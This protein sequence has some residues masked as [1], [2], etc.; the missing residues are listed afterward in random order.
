MNSTV[1]GIDHDRVAQLMAVFGVS[2]TF[3]LPANIYVLWL[4]QREGRLASDIFYFNLSLEEIL[5]SMSIIW[6]NLGYQNTC[7]PCFEVF[8]FSRGL[9]YT[10]RPLFQCLICVE[11]YVG[12]NHPVLFLRFK[13]LRH[14][15]SCCAVGWLL[16]TLS[17]IYSKYTRKNMRHLFIVFTQNLVIFFVVLFC[18]VSVVRTLKRPGPGGNTAQ[19][20]KRNRTKT[21]AIKIL[22]V[23]MA[24]ITVNFVL[25]TA[26]IPLQLYLP[27]AEFIYVY[28][29]FTCLSFISG[30]MQLLIYMQRAEK[31]LCFKMH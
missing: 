31:I 13:P 28:L 8:A 29:T 17:C 6:I 14:R 21:R 16:I 26:P 25:C 18:L 10:G 22:L 7:E 1:E 9:F 15:L 19:S 20:K 4:I 27:E 2:L 30:S 23:T 5:F 11:C 12:V 24:S 3:T